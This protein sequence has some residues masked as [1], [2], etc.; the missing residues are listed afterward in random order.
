ML[1]SFLNG[2]MI[3]YFLEA[4]P[5]FGTILLFATAILL[6]ALA[7]IIGALL[8]LV[9]FRIMDFYDLRWDVAIKV[10]LGTVIG[11]WLLILVC[12]AVSVL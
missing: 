1:A 12:I 9:G 4:G 8:A 2:T 7:I 6:P 3:R 5:Q 10:T 11:S